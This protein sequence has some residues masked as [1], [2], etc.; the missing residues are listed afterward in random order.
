VRVEEWR[1]VCI[2]SWES[3][4]PDEMVQNIVGVDAGDRLSSVKKKKEAPSNL[5]PPSSSSSQ[6]SVRST[7]FSY[8]PILLS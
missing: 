2:C 6:M 8:P 1:L 7:P 5:A 3:S 4:L